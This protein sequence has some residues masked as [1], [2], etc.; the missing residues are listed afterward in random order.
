MFK[1]VASF[2]RPDSQH[3]FFSDI[4]M[5]FDLIK[6]LHERARS[7]QGF[8]GVDEHVYRDDLRCDKALCFDSQESFLKFAAVN[9][10]ILDQRKKLIDLYCAE[11]KHEYKY[12]VIVD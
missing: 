4:Y 5:Q 2:T 1:I 7:H 12:Y 11:T 10:D 9:Q 8:L 3:E 6:T